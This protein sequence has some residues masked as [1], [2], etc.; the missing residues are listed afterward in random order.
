V[1]ILG[2]ASPLGEGQAT[3]GWD[4]AAGTTM[5]MDPVNQLAVNGMVQ[6]QGGANIHNALREAVYKDIARRR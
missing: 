1:Q 6:I 4:G 5:W 3:Y 2:K